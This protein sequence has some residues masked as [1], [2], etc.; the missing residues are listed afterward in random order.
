[1]SYGSSLLIRKYGLTTMITSG[2][3]L[4]MSVDQ[5]L[6]NN[7]E[8]S[9]HVKISYYLPKKITIDIILLIAKKILFNDY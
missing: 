9:F 1:M 6:T 5:D 3:C 7:T 2:T 4:I 8:E